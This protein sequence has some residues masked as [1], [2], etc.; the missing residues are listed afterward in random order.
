MSCVIFFFSFF[1]QSGEASQWK[2][3]YQQGL[4]G[5]AYVLKYNLDVFL[6]ASVA[7]Y[8]DRQM[9]RFQATLSAT[10]NNREG[11]HSVGEMHYFK[12]FYICP[13]LFFYLPFSHSHFVL[14]FQR[15]SLIVQR[16][17]ADEEE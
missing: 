9:G 11:K 6:G 3:C 10:V 15:P 13:F 8:L 16:S 1:G 5:L 7:V 14:L 2:V 4:P 17:A 12:T